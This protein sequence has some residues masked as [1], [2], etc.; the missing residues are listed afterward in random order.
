MGDLGRDGVWTDKD[1]HPVVVAPNAFDLDAVQIIRPPEFAQHVV[2]DHRFQKS[3]LLLL[4][5]S[6]SLFFLLLL[7]GEFLFFLLRGHHFSR[8]V[9]GCRAERSEE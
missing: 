8:N 1:V 4:L 2:A 5:L 3:D 6:D 9:A 7:L